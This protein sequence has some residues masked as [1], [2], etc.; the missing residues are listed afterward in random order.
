MKAAPFPYSKSV[1]HQTHLKTATLRENMVK[2][3]FL[4]R[5]ECV[6]SGIWA[7][8]YM[9][10]VMFTHLSLLLICRGSTLCLSEHWAKINVWGRPSQICELSVLVVCTLAH[11]CVCVFLCTITTCVFQYVMSVCVSSDVA[12]LLGLIWG[13]TGEISGFYHPHIC[14]YPRLWLW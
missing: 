5:H 2:F 11:E 8:A 1:Y 7:H 4:N 3:M 14:V 12:C 10:V 6:W 13:S 9:C